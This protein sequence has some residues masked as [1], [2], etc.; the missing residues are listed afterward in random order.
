MA[1][2]TVTYRQAD[3]ESRDVSVVAES[4]T[5]ALKKAGPPRSEESVEITED[6]TSLTTID[7]RRRGLET[8]RRRSVA[9]PAPRPDL[10][11]NG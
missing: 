8:P 5:E 9:L 2:Y 4:H 1:I 6:R 10:V 11:A 7:A 3:G